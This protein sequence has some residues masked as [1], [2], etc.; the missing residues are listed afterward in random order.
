LLIFV[1][2]FFLIKVSGL[3]EERTFHM[4][5]SF[6]GRRILEDFERLRPALLSFA[7]HLYN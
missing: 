2:L 3:E 4:D 6:F 1:R 7:F 5:L